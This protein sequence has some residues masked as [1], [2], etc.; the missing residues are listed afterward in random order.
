MEDQ[1]S[2]QDSAM[3]L[4]EIAIDYLRQSAKWS[5]FLSILGFIGIGLMLLAAV[6]IS[7]IMGMAN[8]NSGLGNSELSMFSAMPGILSGV[9]ILLAVLYA[10][11]VYYLYKYSTGIKTAL[12]VRDENLL[13][14][15]LGYLKSH[16]KFIGI[17]AIVLMVVYLLILVGVVVAAV[18]FGGS[19]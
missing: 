18:A 5:F 6:F 10:F 1:F 8:P 15:S 3:R 2:H 11:P 16:H 7:S 4:N 9:Y 14:A 12:L 13:T 17:M 19:H